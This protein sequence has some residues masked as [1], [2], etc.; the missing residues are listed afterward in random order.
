[1]KIQRSTA[2]RLVAQL[3]MDMAVAETEQDEIELSPVAQSLIM[4]AVARDQLQA[5]IDKQDGE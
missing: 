2:K 3:E 5:E 4:D 1:M